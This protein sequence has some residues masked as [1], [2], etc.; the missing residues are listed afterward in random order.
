MPLPKTKRTL[1]KANY[2][3]VVSSFEPPNVKPPR[4]EY[5]EA[6]SNKKVYAILLICILVVAEVVLLLALSYA[7][8]S[9]NFPI[10]IERETA[11]R[12]TGAIELANGTY[13][14]E[15]DFGYLFGDGILS[16]NSGAVYDGNWEDNQMDGIGELQ[17]P[18][19]G[20]YTGEFKDSQKSGTGIYK[21]NDGTIYD[22]E[23]YEDQMD[24]QGVCTTAN[25]VT[26]NGIFEN[27][28]FYEGDCDFSN[29]TG[30]YHISYQNGEPYTAEIEFSNGTSYIGTSTLSSLTG[31][32]E[33]V[34][35][36][37]DIYNGSFEDGRRT[38]SGVYTWESGNVYD[39][40]W[41]N[42]KM[43][44]T[45]SFTFEN[46]STLFGQFE[47]NEFTTGSYNVEND[48]GS[49]TFSIKN[50]NPV[51]VLIVLND[52][53]SYNGDMD[54]DGLNGNALIS[55]SN[56]DQYD[57]SVSDGRKYGLGTYTWESGA[58]Y[59][60]S[61]SEDCMNG[62]GTY[63]YP[64]DEDGYKL[65]GEFIDGLPDGEC[66]YYVSASKSY[67]TTWSNG[68]CVKVFE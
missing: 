55:Y 41:L 21:W 38:G 61:W 23:W 47:D 36:N 27:N 62:N 9:N 34:F 35:R 45:G 8:M 59:T 15:T 56:G 57:G 20:T 17:V 67:D 4:D 25:G 43:T 3:A 2:E 22:G 52:G 16:F 19:N 24:G 53:T 14:G 6:I 68:E 66:K 60:G 32:G 13:T 50:G 42:D 54:E 1:Q 44:G 7:G 48:F 37:G 26:Y 64:S 5:T 46:G 63:T 30:T 10:R 58:S 65:V 18:V 40:D 12:R 33:M 29:S 28:T 49:Y 11:I 51:G 31:N 39:G